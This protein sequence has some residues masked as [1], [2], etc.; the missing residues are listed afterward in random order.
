MTPLAHIISVTSI[1]TMMLYGARFAVASGHW[2]MP[3]GVAGWHLA[4]CRGDGRVCRARFRAAVDQLHVDL[5]SAIETP[6]SA[7]LFFAGCV[8]VG[9]SYLSGSMG[10]AIR[11]VSLHPDAWVAFDVVTDCLA[12]VLSVTGISFVMA[13]FSRHRTASFL[14]SGVL[15]LTGLG[16]AVVTL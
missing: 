10:D 16:I 1:W 11:L 7:T 15:V 14:V 4:W 13:G 12:A 6:W 2:L 8:L 5:A 3:I 9:L